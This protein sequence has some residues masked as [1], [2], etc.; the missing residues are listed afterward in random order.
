MLP[1]GRFPFAGHVLACWNW[2]CALLSA[3]ARSAVYLAAMARSG[4]HG[5][6]SIV[7][8]EV[9]YVTLTSGLYAGLQ[10]RALDLRPRFAGNLAVVAGVPIL[11]QLFDWL[12]HRAAGA[13]APWNAT[14]AVCAFAI[15]SALFHLH[16]MRSGAFLTGHRGLAFIED[17]RRIPRLALSFVAKPVV[18]VAELPGRLERLLNTLAAA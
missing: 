1:V 9:V 17:F 5:R 15:V 3:S 12:T 13:A 18:F 4:P 16:V 10:Q 14:A 6:V 11:A 2:K 7:L 8:V